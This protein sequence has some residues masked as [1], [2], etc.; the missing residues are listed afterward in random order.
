MTK[1]SLS[2]L[3]KNDIEQIHDTAIRI[4]SEV[5]VKIESSSVI[6]LL[7]GAGAKVD[8]KKLTALIP[9]RVIV[10][11]LRTVPHSIKIC[12]RRG[13]DYTI[14][15]DG[16]HLISPDGQPPA[17]WDPETSEKRPSRLK[18]VIDMSIVSDALPEVGHLW[19]PVVATDMPAATSTMYEFLAGLAYTSKHIQHGAISAK[20]AEFQIEIG[21]SVL[22]SL[23]DLKKRPIF[24]DV[25]TPISPL[26]W[27]GGE[28]E[29]LVKFS[30]AGVPMAH[31]S[32]GIAGSVTPVT[33]AG[34][35]A[36]VNAENLCGLVMTQVASQGAPSIYSSFSGVMDLKTGV[37]I[38][39]APEGV[40]MDCASVEMARYYKLP[41]LCGGPGNSARTLAAECASQSTMSAMAALLTGS[42]M[43]VGL[44]GMDRDGM[45]CLEKIV[46]DAEIW[47]WLVRIRDGI[48]VD[49]GTLGFDAIKRQGPAG[50]FMSD[51]HT[52]RYMRKDLLIPQF[53]SYHDAKQEGYSYDDLLEYSMKKTKEILATHKPQLFS[54]DEASRVAA[55]AKKYGVLLPDGKQIFEH[56]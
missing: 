48:Q 49:A 33:V 10:D 19:P 30:R 6:N 12:S 43:L 25:I 26:R 3:S 13:V 15:S 40:L 36:V 20:E 37:F 1:A 56:E 50:L 18:D 54:V 51:P 32:M 44:G 45:V 53:T 16:V 5:G 29:A 9:E 7:K 47:K 46:M 35:M 28:V 2:I 41:T 38:G 17:V 42:D 11:A 39:G 4:L 24:S 55:V 23:E 8:E 31:L 34:T 27:D 21:A 22:G 52:A 14:P